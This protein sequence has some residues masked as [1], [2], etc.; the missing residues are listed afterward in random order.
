[1]VSIAPAPRPSGCYRCELPTSRMGRERRGRRTACGPVIVARAPLAA[2][3]RSIWQ[4]RQVRQGS[5]VAAYAGRDTKEPTLAVTNPSAEN[6]AH[7]PT[8][9]TAM[10][11]CRQFG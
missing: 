6:R 9:N 3:R 4:F 2:Q 5:G 10:H 7:G 11:P 8:P 1:M